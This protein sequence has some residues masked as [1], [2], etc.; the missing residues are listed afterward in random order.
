MCASFAVH[1]PQIAAEW[2]TDKNGDLTPY[3]LTPFSGE[4]VWWQCSVNPSHE[5]QAIVANRVNGSGCP[6][7]NLGWTLGNIRCFVSSLKEHLD[8]FTAAELYLLFQQN[9]L[10]Q[11][12]G[13]GK[14]FVKALATGRF[15]KEEIEKFI[16]AEPS[17]VDQFVQEPAQTLEAL[18]T[19]E[20]RPGDAEDDILNR[21]NTVE[22]VA[23]EGEQLLPVVQTKDVFSSL[24]LQVISSADEE[25]VEFLIASGLAKIWKHAYQ[26]EAAAVAQAEDVPGRGI[27][28]AG[29]DQVP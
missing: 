13:K 27:R 12:Q 21:A 3:S 6:F 22:Q 20:P 18:E 19:T 17:L 4:K 8:T 23:E 5:W 28:R 10:L 1:H 9:G 29:P 14:T 26:D 25:A 16:Q 2:H 7:C 15:P 11:V 24:G